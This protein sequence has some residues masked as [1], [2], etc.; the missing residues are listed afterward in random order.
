[1]LKAGSRGRE[2]PL[3]KLEKPGSGQVRVFK[4]SWRKVGQ[5]GSRSTKATEKQD[6]DLGRD[7]PP[8]QIRPVLYKHRQ[9]V[10]EIRKHS[11]RQWRYVVLHFPGVNKNAVGCQIS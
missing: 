7:D 5:V 2:R 9:D 4:Q 11:D 6:G 3:A 8:I 1:V 10:R